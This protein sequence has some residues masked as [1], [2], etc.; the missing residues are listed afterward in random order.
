VPAVESEKNPR[1]TTVVEAGTLN[2]MAALVTAPDA[3]VPQPEA[4]RA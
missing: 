3:A 1:P 4:I 2:A